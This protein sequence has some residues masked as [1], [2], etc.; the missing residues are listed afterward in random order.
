[1]PGY[2]FKNNISVKPYLDAFKRLPINNIMVNMILETF[3]KICKQAMY[4]FI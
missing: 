1:M 4:I 2:I 3:N